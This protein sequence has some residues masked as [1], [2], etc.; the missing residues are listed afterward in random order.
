MLPAWLSD[1]ERIFQAKV[2]PAESWNNY[3]A[4]L[5]FKGGSRWSIGCPPVPWSLMDS[6]CEGYDGKIKAG[7]RMHL[8]NVQEALRTRGWVHDVTN[9]L[10]LLGATL[11]H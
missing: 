6:N 5:K 9:D 10:V 11:Q 1:K 4:T 7:S 2:W 8:V 3:D